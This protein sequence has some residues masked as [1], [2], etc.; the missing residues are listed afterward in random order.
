MASWRWRF[1]ALP[2]LCFLINL[3]GFPTLCLAVSQ[4]RTTWSQNTLN[5]IMMSI[6][7]GL[8]TC[9]LE[10]DWSPWSQKPLCPKPE[11]EDDSVPTD[12]VFTFAA[13]RGNQ[14]VSIITTPDLAA[15]ITESLD[16]S[17][18]PRDL[19]DELS[20]SPKRSDSSAYE[21]RDLVGRGKGVVAKRR[22]AK[23]ETLMV[24]FP[25]LVIRLDFIN[26]D[27]YTQRQKRLTM[28]VAVKRL[29]PEQQKAIAA[30]ARSTGGEPIL[31]ALRTNGFGIEIDGVQHLA[32][33]IDGSVSKHPVS[34]RLP[35]GYSNSGHECAC[36]S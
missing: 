21:I 11:E 15:G 13:F 32:L 24:G 16:D 26:E 7:Q 2:L 9:P 29:P 36:K 31:D 25:V 28:E 5:G 30:L 20:S 6:H 27:R 17:R 10:G 35:N 1:G 34:L 23:H 18:L 14:G 12:C 22:F 8:E 4:G 19:R 33:F 3:Q